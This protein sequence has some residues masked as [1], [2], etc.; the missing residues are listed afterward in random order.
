MEKISGKVKE[1][2]GG[3]RCKK[4][5]STNTIV[6]E[7]HDRQCSGGCS[8]TG[9]MHGNTQEDTQ[10]LAVITT[11]ITDNTDLL[12]GQDT[13]GWTYSIKHRYYIKSASKLKLVYVVDSSQ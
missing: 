5:Q 10:R 13:S 3:G 11:R 6:E 1:K 7:D 9:C 2:M 8:G 12:N 4:Q